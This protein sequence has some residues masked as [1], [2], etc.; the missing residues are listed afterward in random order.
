MP[1]KY[2]HQHHNQ[3]RPSPGAEILRDLYVRQNKGVDFLMR[4]FRTHIHAIRRW[5]HEAG[6]PLR[7]PGRGT[8]RK[9]FDAEWLRFV[10]HD[11]ERSIAEIASLLGTTPKVVLREM[12]RLGLP[13]RK[14]GARPHAP[15]RKK[16][17]DKS[18]YVQ[19]YLPGHPGANNLGYVREHRLV[20]ETKL[21][22]VLQPGEVVHHLDENKLNN[23]PDN[24]AL[25]PSMAA[26]IRHHNQERSSAWLLHQLPDDSLAELY[27]QKSTVT[28]A[29]EFGTNST[30]V[31]R[32]LR[33]RG[34]ELRRGRRPQASLAGQ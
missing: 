34:I 30:T 22:R 2:H 21:G 1:E 27:R 25:F 4:H 11:E 14:S 29:R 13:R 20:M 3:F 24:L 19:V 8:P 12:N 5:L 31:Q 16:L 6:I 32:L 33:R 28:I 7:S 9:E 10:Y 23:A 15:R 18:Q 26:H 17:Q